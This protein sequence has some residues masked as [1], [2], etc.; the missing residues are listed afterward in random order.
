MNNRPKCKAINFYRAT[1]ESLQD[2]GIRKILL[3]LTLKA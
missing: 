1:G 3:D 2:V